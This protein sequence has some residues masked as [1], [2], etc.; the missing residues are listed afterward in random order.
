MI[1][2]IIDAGTTVRYELRF[3][4]PDYGS[5]YVMAIVVFDDDDDDE[6]DYRLKNWKTYLELWERYNKSGFYH[7]MEVDFVAIWIDDTVIRKRC[8]EGTKYDLIAM[9]KDFENSKMDEE[10]DMEE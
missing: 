6:I 9:I 5:N 1:K 10:D 8:F 4:H 3:N 7:T 2:E